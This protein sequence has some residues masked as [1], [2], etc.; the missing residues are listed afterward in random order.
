[1]ECTAIDLSPNCS[2]WEQATLSLSHGGLGLWYVFLHCSATYTCSISARFPDHINSLY[3]LEAIN[4]YNALV[5]PMKHSSSPIN[6]FCHRNLNTSSFNPSCNASTLVYRARLLSIS[7][8]H[9]SSWQNAPALG[10]HAESQFAINSLD[11]KC[12][13]SR[14][15]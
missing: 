13:N 3:L 6:A 10:L 5:L 7:S 1:M 4:I 11:A 14:M 8:P 15:N 9:A 12:V 2:V